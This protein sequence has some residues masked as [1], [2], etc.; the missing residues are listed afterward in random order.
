MPK[1]LLCILF[2]ICSIFVFSG[3]SRM[4]YAQI[5][6]PNGQI[7]EF[8]GV[9]VDKSIIEN[10]GL[11]YEFVLNCIKDEIDAQLNNSIYNVLGVTVSSEKNSAT[12][13]VTG[14][15]IFANYNV[16]CQVFGI[17]PNE[18]KESEIKKGFLFDREILSRHSLVYATQNKQVI[19]QNI[20]ERLQTQY[21]EIPFDFGNVDCYY[22]YAVPLSYAQVE[23]IRTNASYHYDKQYSNYSLRHFVWHYDHNN[24]DAEAVIY[25][26]HIH[27]WAWYVLGIGLTIVFMLV[28][29]CVAI[30][31]KTHPKTPPQNA[32]IVEIK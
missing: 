23:R 20:T 21:P 7:G 2:V 26:N 31:K 29:L 32:E 5:I 12:G 10:A 3:C 16:Y 8:I 30:I 19:Y 15:I 24:P 1:K 11:D 17:D 22:S 4:E 9:N 6:Y 13:S 27:S 25:V 14:Q 28:M 18:E